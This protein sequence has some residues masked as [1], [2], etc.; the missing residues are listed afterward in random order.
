MVD[1]REEPG[2]YCTRCWIV[3]AGMLPDGEERI[4]HQF[5]G[6]HMVRGHAIGHGIKM[7]TVAPVEAFQSPHGF[8]Q[9]LITQLTIFHLRFSFR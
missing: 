3:G 8:D 4:L 1:D 2:T 9:E 6:D 7:P 5:L